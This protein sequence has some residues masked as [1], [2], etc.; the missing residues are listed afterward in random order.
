MNYILA[1]FLPA[2]VT[3]TGVYIVLSGVSLRAMKWPMQSLSVI[4][5]SPAL[6]VYTLLHQLF[7]R[8]LFF[9]PLRKIPGPPFGHILYGQFRN[10]LQAEAGQ[11]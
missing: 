4:F 11:R 9:S 2:A 7:F 1:R 5:F 3:S 6:T 10:I 8:P